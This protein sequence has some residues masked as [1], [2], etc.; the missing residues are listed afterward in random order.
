MHL[1]ESSIVHLLSFSLIPNFAIASRLMLEHHLFMEEEGGV[2][3][4]EEE[5]KY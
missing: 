3:R 1:T 5:Q 4:E 2:R